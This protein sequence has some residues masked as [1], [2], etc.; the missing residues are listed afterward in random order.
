MSGVIHDWECRVHGVFTKRVKAGTVPPCPKGCTP[1]FVHLV[2][3]MAPS[4]GTDRVRTATRL[5]REVADSQGLSDI[6]V[7]PSTPGDSV[8]A[9]NFLR[10]QNQVRARAVDFA[11]YMSALTNRSNELS[12]LGFGHPY[13]PSEW[14]QTAEGKMRH[15]GA[16]P[17]VTDTPMNQFGVE[18]QRVKEK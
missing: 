11:T 7:S 3:L 13:E 1:Y 10:S 17:P 15:A 4:I 8:A 2:H 9:K 16:Q 5:V 6:D 14:K 18:M 12:K